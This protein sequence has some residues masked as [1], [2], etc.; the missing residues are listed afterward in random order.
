MISFARLPVPA[1]VSAAAGYAVATS[2]ASAQLAVAAARGTAT[3]AGAVASATAEQAGGVL[4]RGL[5]RA[6]AGIPVP[7]PVEAG[8]RRL[9]TGLGH[10]AD[11]GLRRSTRRVWHEDGRAHIEVKGLT[12][13]GTGHRR[14]AGDVTAALGAIKGVHW[15]EVNAV[16]RHVLLAF[17]EDEVDLDVILEAIEAVEEAHGA[18]E[19]GFERTTPEHPADDAPVTMAAAALG[20]DL[21]GLGVATA[22]TAAGVTLLPRYARIPLMFAET[23]PRLR[24]T[25]ENRLGRAH[26]EL[27]M[28]VAT[29]AVNA[30]S[31]GPAPLAVDSVHHFLKF[32]EVR[33]RRAVWRRRERELV[34][35]GKGLPDEAHERRRRPVPFPQ[36]P[37][38]R[39]GD[40]TALTSLLGAGGMLAFTR[41]PGRAGDLMLATMPKAA[42]QGREAFCAVLGHLLTRQGVVPMD[43]TC[44]RR[45][46]RIGVVVI[47]ST[48]LCSTEPQVL[49]ATALD[50]AFDDVAVWQLAQRF[51]SGSE[52]ADLRADGPWT[53]GEW[54]IERAADARPGQ[55]DGPVA[56]TIDMLD[57]DGRRVGRARIGTALDPLA[58][59]LLTAARSAADRV[60]L[61][62]HES[63][64]DLLG[65]A[66]EV[67]PVAEAGQL[68][69]AVR[70]Y[71]SEGLGVLLVSTGHN[72]ALD[73]ADV[74]LGVLR[75][76]DGVC[77]SADLICGPGL[78]EAWRVLR[79]VTVAKRVS[80][81]S[82]R[83]ALGGSALGA[84]ITV[85]GD[86]RRRRRGLSM[87]P[88]HTAQLLA[89]TGGAVSAFGLG[90]LPAPAPVLRADWHAVTAPDA[91]ARLRAYR[92]D[93]LLEKAETPSLPE[94]VARTAIGLADSVPVVAPAF[95]RLVLR[96]ARGTVTLAEAVVEELRDPLTPVLALGAAASAI[97]GSS[98]DALLVGGVMAGNAVISA[99]QR[100]RAERALHGLLLG[101]RV[102]ARR[103]AWSGAGKGRPWDEGLLDSPTEC[104]FADE[105][106]PGDV[107]VLGPGDVVPADA[108]LLHV[109]DLEVD[110]SAL[111]GESLPV[112]KSV[113]ATPGADLADRSCMLY[114]GCTVLAGTAHAVVTA[115]GAMTEAGRAAAVAGSAAPPAG[116][117]ARLGDLTRIALPAAGIGGLAV[118]GLA[119]LRGVP[120]PQAVASGV[121]IA[122]AAVPEGLP[123]VATVAQ[124]AAA[125]RLSR[126]GVLVRS[127]RTLEALGRVDTVCFDK[128][129]TLTEGR[130]SLTRVAGLDGDLEPGSAAA[131]QVV[132]VAAR[133]CPQ[134]KGDKV[135]THATDIA[136]VQAAAGLDPAP[137]GEPDGAWRLLAEQPFESSRGYSASLGS[138]DG[139]ALLA[140]KG[141]PEVVLDRCVTVM[142]QG[143]QKPLDAA[144]RKAASAAV[145][146]LADDGLRVLAVA[147]ATPEEPD[148]ALVLKSVEGDIGALAADLTLL[149]FVAIADTPRPT[150]TAAITRLAAAGVRITM[151]TGDHPSTAAAIAR[152]LGIPDADRVVTGA[153]LDRLSKTGRDALIAE[154]TV[155][156]RVSPEHKVRIV[157]AMQKAGRVV[158]MTGD[159]SNDA[160]AIRLADVGIALAGFGSVSARSAADLVLTDPDPGSLV[161][162]LAEGRALWGS[163]RDAVSILVGG[164]AGEVAFTVLGTAL[165]GQAPLQHASAAA[166]EH[167]DRHAPRA[168]GRPRSGQAGQRGGRR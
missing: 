48:V 110:E 94:Q 2:A 75:G 15:A 81:R 51:I 163:V 118:T 165:S 95:R 150:A 66:D 63:I 43:G 124:L 121:A 22:A 64:G 98:V 70:G 35:D 144:G 30:G 32:A 29:S 146:R 74:G 100:T 129:G 47:E 156:A 115:V 137:E 136:V 123:L 162:A 142:T 145:H 79:A 117:Q 37:V 149:G 55:V 16:T 41:D 107:I 42:R 69:N 84:L 27:L 40:R 10:L 62:E 88:V 76:N 135:L 166:G 19:E 71:Q 97:V 24:H 58:D 104:C 7:G 103:T 9:G 59:A 93:A 151:I 112:A 153:Q 78:R 77:W 67:V 53:C 65:W 106:R 38:E 122:V 143:S 68:R 3:V 83:L 44:L 36:G 25:M 160:A 52:P 90:R 108:R 133:A 140:V 4:T 157:Q 72:A 13:R 99:A 91:L 23:Y 126:H 105:L 96:P 134:P 113:S 20:A 120:L 14:V 111:T 114:E 131:R 82:S 167:D 101:E 119:A 61:T 116:M 168:R 21:A 92:L 155:F 34:G 148:A 54:H 138:I 73:A 1:A 164:N 127:S 154:S 102:S 80:G 11:A 139:R 158:A 87:S 46:D 147:Q 50:S 57:R 17:D 5:P 8:A 18:A 132:Q 128:T 85:A 60:V 141:A 49:S 125:R 152:Q 130:L 45:L 26:A 109:A 12:G 161:D 39:L 28:S 33:S 31:V 89:I 6:A 159:G 56:L 86:G